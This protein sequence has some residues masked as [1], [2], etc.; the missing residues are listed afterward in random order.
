ME[1]I[2]YFM[3]GVIVAAL[4]FVIAAMIASIL[5]PQADTTSVI[6]NGVQHVVIWLHHVEAVRPLDDVERNASEAPHE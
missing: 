3:R 4:L 6:D 1:P 5:S 2:F